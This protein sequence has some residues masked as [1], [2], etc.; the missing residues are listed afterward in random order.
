MTVDLHLTNPPRNGSDRRVKHIE[1]FSLVKLFNGLSSQA[2]DLDA[3]CVSRR[4]VVHSGEL[5]ANANG[6]LRAEP[7]IQFHSKFDSELIK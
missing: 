1:S 7:T 3:L 6:E 5:R 4:R 2:T